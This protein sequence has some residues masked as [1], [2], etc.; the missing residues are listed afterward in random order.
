MYSFSF[1][2]PNSNKS[3]LSFNFAIASD[4][5]RGLFLF[6]ISF[7]SSALSMSII[8]LKEELAIADK[9]EPDPFTNGFND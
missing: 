6:T 1:I 9:I 3:L 2:R 7:D 8:V 5:V 4:L